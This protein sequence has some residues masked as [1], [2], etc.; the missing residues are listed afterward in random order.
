MFDAFTENERILFL[1]LS[2]NNGCCCCAVHFFRPYFTTSMFVWLPG[3]ALVTTA[4]CWLP[5]RCWSYSQYSLESCYATDCFWYWKR[6]INSW[7]LWHLV[8]WYSELGFD[9]RNWLF[10]SGIRFEVFPSVWS[11]YGTAILSPV[12]CAGRILSS[13]GRYWFHSEDIDSAGR[14]LLVYLIGWRIWYR[15][16][17]STEQ[18]GFWLCLY[19]IRRR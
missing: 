14:I 3:T 11:H 19:K 12:H 15:A 6:Y 1:V 9:I 17:S 18:G 16:V 2:G 8:F 13:Q 5:G 7:R 10:E 4:L